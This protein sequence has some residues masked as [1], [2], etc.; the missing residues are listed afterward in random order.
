MTELKTGGSQGYLRIA[1]EEAF[2]PPE[3]IEAY[4]KLLAAGDVDPGFYSLMG[5]Y[6]NSQAERPRFIFDRLQ[7][8]GELRLADMDARGIDR[9]VIGLTAPGTQVMTAEDGHALSILA[10]DRLSEACRKYPDRFTGMAAVA[11][12]AGEKAGQEI[13]RAVSKLGMKAVVIN[14]HIHGEYLD[15]PK[16]GATLEAAEAMDVPIYLHP[17]TPPADMIRPMLESGL[18]GAIFGFGVETGMHALRL[19]VKGVFDRYPKLQVIIGHM[20]EALPYWMYRLDFMHQAGIR[21][22]RY[23]FLKPLKKEKVSNYLKENFYITN[24]GVAWEPAIKFAQQ[25]IGEDR[26]LYAMDFPYQCPPEE[27][28]ILDNMDMPLETK[29]KFF[30]TNAERVFKL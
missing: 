8:L 9:Q 26:V 16:F 10:N 2:A 24:S 23:D 30:Q 25:V 17:Q 15:D 22:A 5:F 3:M 14:S 1:T 19:I 4:R 13:E 11:P 18:D 12:H 21:A 7:D 6:I 27:V 20:G 28:T 29:K